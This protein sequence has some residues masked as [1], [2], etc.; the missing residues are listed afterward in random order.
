MK[1]IR[2][3]LISTGLAAALTAC[4][5]DPYYYPPSGRHYYPY[6]YPYY[7]D[8]YYYPGV[9]VYFQF[10][11]GYYFYYSRNRWIRTRVL[12]PHIHL[13][14]WDRVTLRLKSDKPYLK[15]KEHIHKYQPRPRPP[16]YGG[17]PPVSKPAPGSPVWKQPAQPPASKPAPGT[18]PWQ[19]PKEQSRPAPR[20]KPGVPYIERR[21]TKIS[22]Q[23]QQR[24]LK[25]F[26]EHQKKQKEYE[27]EWEEKSKRGRR[28]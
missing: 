6:Y 2:F 26:K 4:V 14:P 18:Q 9:R 8:Y 11:T 28:N 12:P 27:K 21:D 16:E 19:M 3:F 5:Y 23:E 10:S 20:T 7:Y 22:N 1:L 24:N 17:K 25:L 13:D 15:H